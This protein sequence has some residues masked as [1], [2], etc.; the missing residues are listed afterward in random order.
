MA[1]IA[2]SAHANTLY[3]VKANVTEHGQE[4]SFPAVEVQDNGQPVRTQAD[5]CTYIATLN[6][7]I[8]NTLT[9]TATM[10]CSDETTVMPVMILRAAS[11]SAS[12]EL[13]DEGKVLWKYS[14]EVESVQ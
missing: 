11:D 9:I 1:L 3:Q 5:G 8:Q 12:Y 6:Q 14:V 2:G 13:E 10:V 7:Y 4:I